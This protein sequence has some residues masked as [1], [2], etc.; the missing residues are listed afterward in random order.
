MVVDTALNEPHPFI[1]Q[2]QYPRMA[3]I[4]PKLDLEEG[5]LEL[6]TTHMKTTLV[7][8]LHNQIEP[9]SEGDKEKRLLC[10]VWGTPVSAMDE[11]EDAAR[12]FHQAL[13]VTKYDTDM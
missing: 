12:W 8:P 5:V 6:K 1:S 10:S 9:P 13:D 11:G 4:Q 3:L 7:I 2:R